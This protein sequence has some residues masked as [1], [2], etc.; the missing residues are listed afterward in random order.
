M[1][2]HLTNRARQLFGERKAVHIMEKVKCYKLKNGEQRY[3]FRLFAGRD[4]LT[5]KYKYVNRTGFKTQSEALQAL[6]EVQQDIETGEVFELPE[7]PTFKAVYKQFIKQHATRVKGST[8]Y[9]IR[10]RFKSAILP[11]MSDWKIEDIT[12]LMCQNVINEWATKYTSTGTLSMLK[13]D[14]TMVFKFAMR[15]EL[16]NKNPMSLATLPRMQRK[17]V[18]DKF[19][20][21]NE[22]KQF[23]ECAKQQEQLMYYSI[24]YLL[25]FTGLRVGEAL[26]LTWGDIDFKRKV[27]HVNKTVSMNEQGKRVVGK[28]KTATST[29]V[30]T[31]DNSTLDVLKK[32]YMKDRGLAGDINAS[33]LIFHTERSKDKLCQAPMVKQVCL[34]ICKN[35]NLRYITVHGLRHTHCSL[36]FEA[37]ASIQDVKTRLGHSNIQTTM[38][39]YTHVTEQQQEKAVALFDEFMQA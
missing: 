27:L 7:H 13:S 15:M 38:N 21:K 34:R 22:L 16:V 19:Y 26:A 23:L 12:P 30:I 28:P 17:D 9:N 35:N 39:I 8:L 11:T 36:L 2:N 1:I 6:A 32:W 29:R 24:F 18:R 10:N 4:P 33:K 14:V 25:A 37:G 20:T 3:K 31:L 5:G